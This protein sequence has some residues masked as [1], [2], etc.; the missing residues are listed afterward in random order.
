M[1]S[2]PWRISPILWLWRE[3]QRR[4]KKVEK[5]KKENNNKTT[6]NGA[7]A[8]IGFG[9]GNHIRLIGFGV[10]PP[11]VGPPQSDE[12]IHYSP[13]RATPAGS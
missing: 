10:E 12:D 13:M 9:K 1:I 5:K 3:N 4:K 7:L 8:S 2:N 6:E 11:C